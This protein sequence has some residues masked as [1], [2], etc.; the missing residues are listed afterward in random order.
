M[1]GSSRPSTRSKPSTSSLRHEATQAS[2]SNNSGSRRHDRCGSRTVSSSRPTNTAPTDSPASSEFSIASIRRPRNRP[3]STIYSENWTPS[4][5]LPAEEHGSDDED[6]DE[7]DAYSAGIEPHNPSTGH[8]NHAHLQQHGNNGHRLSI[9]EIPTTTDHSH[10]SSGRRY[11]TQQQQ[12]GPL[13][14][15]GPSGPNSNETPRL[16]REQSSTFRCLRPSSW[17]VGG[18]GADARNPNRP[19]ADRQMWLFCLGFLLPFAWMLAAL[20]PVPAKQEVP[21]SSY[22]RHGEKG[23]EEKVGRD[24]RAR[25]RIAET[26]SGGVVD[27][28]AQMMEA[29]DLAVAEKERVRAV[30]WR[31]LNRR[32]SVVGVAIIIVVVAVAVPLTVV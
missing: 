4:P 22:S 15:F 12:P 27:V 28:E 30:W 13:R 20:L 11:P 16:R 21:A 2:G 25:G 23:D 26:G 18:S 9:S 7:Y 6:D 24:D 3:H 32:M 8:S 19:A 1:I 31:T 14:Y 17:V 5:A 10:D 29:Q